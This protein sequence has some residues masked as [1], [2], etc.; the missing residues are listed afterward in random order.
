MTKFSDIYNIYRTEHY[1][2]R[3][4]YSP[5]FY[6]EMKEE[7]KKNKEEILDY[8]GPKAL[9]DK[10]AGVEGSKVVIEDNGISHW[11]M[12]ISTEKMSFSVASDLRPDI[13]T[14]KWTKHLIKRYV[15]KLSIP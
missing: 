14:S 15:I 2:I 11:G 3:G 6:E 8:Y 10:L 5:F 1:S 12:V 4:Y 7:R 9:A 13:Y